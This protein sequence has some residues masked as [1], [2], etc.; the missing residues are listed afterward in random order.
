MSIPTQRPVFLPSDPQL[1]EPLAIEMR[2]KLLAAFTWLGESYLFAERQLGVL[3]DGREYVFPAVLAGGTEYLNVLPDTHL[4]NHSY[5]D[6]SDSDNIDFL[7]QSAEIRKRVGLVF[8]FNYKD[9]F[10]ASWQTATIEGV[11]QL[12]LNFFQDNAFAAGTARPVAFYTNPGEVYAGYDYRE[13]KQQATMKPYGI[14]RLDFEAKY[15]SKCP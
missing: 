10:G 3:P 12:V 2:T 13:A 6:V 15:S 5:F 1:F 9:V 11:K 4:Q 14:L 8:F 7:R